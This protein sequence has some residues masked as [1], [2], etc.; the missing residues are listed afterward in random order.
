MTNWKTL[1]EKKNSET[2]VL[3]PHWDSRSTIAA[4]LEC[5]EDRVDDALRP[6]LRSGEIQ[7][8]QFD[9]W[10]S[11]LKRKVRTVAYAETAKISAAPINGER[12]ERIVALKKEGKSWAEIGRAIG[13]SGDTARGIHRRATE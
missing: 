9:V 1:V 5:S 4:Q 3:P 2:F 11:S 10:D 6:G 12:V 7:K 13:V 8:Q